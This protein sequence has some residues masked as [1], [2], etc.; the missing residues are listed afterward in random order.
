MVLSDEPSACKQDSRKCP[1]MFIVRGDDFWS[2]QHGTEYAILINNAATPHER[3]TR[4]RLPGRGLPVTL[5]VRR[6]IHCDQRPYE[7]GWGSDCAAWDC[8]PECCRIF[9]GFVDFND[10]SEVLLE[11]LE[12]FGSL[13]C[14]KLEHENSLRET[15]NLRRRKP[16]TK[17]RRS[18]RSNRPSRR[19]NVPGASTNKLK[20][21]R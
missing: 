21:E 8:F 17:T 6:D 2:H 7:G 15:G 1:Q 20:A 5:R 11:D 3:L 13:P 16:H 4:E 14:L 19:R 12:H 10:K 9:S 18:A